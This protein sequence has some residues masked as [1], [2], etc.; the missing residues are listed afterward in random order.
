MAEQDHKKNIHGTKYSLHRSLSIME[1]DTKEIPHMT[2]HHAFEDIVKS[3]RA[4]GPIS[5]KVA[6][7]FGDRVTTFGQ[8]N[9]KA[10]SLARALKFQLVNNKK[11]DFSGDKQHIVALFMS[12]S[13]TAVMSALSV[14]KLGAAYTVMDKI[15]PPD[16]IKYIID[17]AGVAAIVATED[18]IEYLKAANLGDDTLVL[19]LSDLLNYAQSANLSEDNI[20]DID[21]LPGFDEKLGMCIVIYTSGS[22]GSPKGVR[23][24][25]ASL[26]NNFN[27]IWDVVNLKEGDVTSA[28]TSLMFIP[29]ATDIFCPLLQGLPVVIVPKSI[30]QD[31]EELIELLDRENVS[32]IPFIAPS[33]LDVILQ[34]VQMFDDPKIQTLRFANVGGEAVPTQIVH[35]FYDYFNEGVVLVDSWGLTE[36]SNDA[37]WMEFRGKKDIAEGVFD[38]GVSIG[39]PLHNTIAYIV[40]EKGEAVSHGE[41]GELCIS[42]VCVSPGYMDKENAFSFVPNTLRK[43]SGHETLFK[44]GD[45]AKIKNGRLVYCGRRDQMVKIRGYRVNISEIETAINKLDFIEKVAVLPVKRSETDVYLVGFYS[46]RPGKSAEANDIRKACEASLTPYMIPERFVKLDEM[47]LKEASAKTDRNALKQLLGK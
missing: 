28:M 23:I 20:P 29:H 40:N 34:F 46:C 12:E 10:N 27:Y 8:L 1:G 38:E 15:L 47:P 26:L 41:V 35:D 19:S 31:P 33:L 6:I 9:G 30:K 44:T 13:D 25:H 18:N 43:Q 14:L 4:S 45:F 17:Q 37:T 32:V 16:R 7:R 36:T 42:G 21:G 2:I 11:V 3:S 5:E 24:S 22:T 39:V